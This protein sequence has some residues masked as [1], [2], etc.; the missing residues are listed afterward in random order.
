MSSNKY[1]LAEFD[2]DLKQLGGMI[3]NF[4]S[5]NKGKTGGGKRGSKKKGGACGSKHY[6][7]SL[8]GGKPSLDASSYNIGYKMKEADGK[9]W[10]VK[11]IK[12]VKKWVYERRYKVLS[13]NGRPYPK[14]STYSGTEPKVAAKKAAKWICKQLNM[15]KNCTIIFQLKETTRGSDKRSYGPYKAHFQKLDK[16]KTFKF[17]GMNKPHTQTH[18][19]I[20]KLAKK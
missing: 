15:N 12:G 6:N 18:D 14:Y 11:K 9:T 2:S 19:I 3:E 8:S 17:P 7:N 10:T 4:Y 5:Q 16:P 13:V 1:S 20:V